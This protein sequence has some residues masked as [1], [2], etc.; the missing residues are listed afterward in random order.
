MSSSSIRRERAA[1]GKAQRKLDREDI[2]LQ[3]DFQ[4]GALRY[5]GPIITTSLT[6]TEEHRNALAAAGAPIPSPVSC[7]FLLDTGADGCVVKHEIAVQAGLKLINANAQ[8]HGVGVDTTGKVY[9]G[10]VLFGVAS[11]VVDGAAHHIHV[12]TQVMSGDLHSALF[13]GL[14]GRDVLQ[15]FALT[16]DGKT[17]R[18]TMKYHRP[19]A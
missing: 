1:Q 7:R 13:D 17:G 12:D 14:I 19:K 9:I 3:F 5:H 18:V 8:L 2:V 11:R 10:R 15:Y 6:I 16:Y 4:A